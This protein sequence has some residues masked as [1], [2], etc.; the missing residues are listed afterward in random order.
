M[1]YA[2]NGTSALRP[3]EIE[4]SS[5]VGSGKL[6][7]KPLYREKERAVRVKLKLSPLTVL[8]GAA[9]LFMLFLVVFSYMRLY[10]A[11]SSVSSLK[12]EI[13][14]LEEEQQRLTA[15]YEKGLDL[16]AVEARAKKLGLRE[17]LPSQIVYVEV[18]AGD[19]TEV[20]EAQE[21]GNIF[22]QIYDA[23]A[24]TL[25]DAVEYFS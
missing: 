20:F 8:G 19:T 14:E 22:R 9:A 21:K 16:E 7:E 3:Q 25:S 18:A 24:G 11:Q 6:P 4:H 13:L 1:K 12:R 5:S 23:L 10:E 2:V 15:Q 17:P